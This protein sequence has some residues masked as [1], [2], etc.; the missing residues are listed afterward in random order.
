MVKIDLIYNSEYVFCI[1]SYYDK[2]SLCKFKLHYT[3]TP[4]NT[5]TILEETNNISSNKYFANNLTKSI[6]LNNIPIN[7]VE[8]LKHNNI[9]HY[10]HEM[11]RKYEPKTDKSHIII[12]HEFKLASF[13]TLILMFKFNIKHVI[14]N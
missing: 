8:V 7:D 3:M 12:L 9:L 14:D 2:S 13:E 6:L 4:Y 1:D 10:S 5:Y 11:S